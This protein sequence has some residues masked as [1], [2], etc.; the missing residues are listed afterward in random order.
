[1]ER[2]KHKIDA[3]DKA[4]GRIASKIAILLRGKNKPDF[5]PHKDMGDVVLV[6]NVDKMKITGRK[7]EQKKYYSHSGYPGGLKE[8]PMGELMEK[9][10][11]EVLR[12]AVLGMLPKNKLRAKQIKRLKF[13]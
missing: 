3:T 7:K 13:N 1:M 10:P 9:K 5:E 8:T 11:E 4:P 12:R 2:K 6:E